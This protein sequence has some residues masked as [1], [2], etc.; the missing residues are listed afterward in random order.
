MR[1]WEDPLAAIKRH[2]RASAQRDKTA[3]VELDVR[4]AESV[5]TAV[6]GDKPLGKDAYLLVLGVMVSNAP[7]ADV[8]EHRSRTRYAVQSALSVAHFV[9][10]DA[11]HLGLLEASGGIR[12]PFE[13]FRRRPGLSKEGNGLDVKVLVVWIEE[14]ASR[15]PPT[16]RRPRSSRSRG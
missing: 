14:S 1:L 3:P 4:K 16:A 15:R 11:Q 6:V 9:P 7:Y 5:C 13:V 10:E 8:S 2:Q 12:V